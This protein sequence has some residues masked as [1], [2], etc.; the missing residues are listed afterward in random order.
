VGEEADPAYLGG[1]CPGKPDHLCAWRP[2]DDGTE[3]VIAFDKPYEYL[4]WL[5]WLLNHFLLPWGYVLNGKMSWQGETEDDTGV[6]SV[7][8][9]RYHGPPNL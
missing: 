9:K 4:K 2:N 7:E 3:L 5:Q 6:I 8:K 1:V